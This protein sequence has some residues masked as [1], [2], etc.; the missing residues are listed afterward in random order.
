MKSKLY[1]R[2]LTIKAVIRFANTSK[3]S[4]SDVAKYVISR[5][6]LYGIDQVIDIAFFLDYRTVSSLITDFPIQSGSDAFLSIQG[7]LEEAVS[8]DKVSLIKRYFE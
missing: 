1:L 8:A 4:F 3:L 5:H 2:K 7:W 6:M